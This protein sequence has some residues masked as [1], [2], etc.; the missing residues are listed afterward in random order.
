VQNNVQ[1]SLHQAK[2]FNSTKATKL[3]GITILAKQIPG[4]QRSPKEDDDY[5]RSSWGLCTYLNGTSIFLCIWAMASGLILYYFQLD[6]LLP[7]TD[8]I[9][10]ICTQ[11][12]SGIY[13]MV[14][15]SN[16][17]F[18]IQYCIKNYSTYW[19]VTVYWILYTT[20]T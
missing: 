19:L 15:V 17:A 5:H 14:L 1:W 9:A 18:L 20:I 2:S 3:R 11:K 6:F 7:G 13:S 12:V 10:Y 16:F 8:F 4:A